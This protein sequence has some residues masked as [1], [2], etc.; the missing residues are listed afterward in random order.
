MK[1]PATH[2]NQSTIRLETIYT[3]EDEHASPTNH[4]IR[5]KENDHLPNLY[6]DMIQPLKSSGV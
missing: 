4:Q 3:L 5:F 2:Y 1:K 6:E